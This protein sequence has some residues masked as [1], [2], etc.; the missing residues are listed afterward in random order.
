MADLT[1]RR[2]LEKMGWREGEGLGQRGDGIK[3]PVALRSVE[4]RTGLGKREADDD[5]LENA[6]KRSR[7]VLPSERTAREAPREFYCDVCD[8]QYATVSEFSN[9]LSSY[10]HHHRKRFQA[11]AQAQKNRGQKKQDRSHHFLQERIHRAK[12]QAA[13]NDEPPA[14]KSEE[15]PPSFLLPP[16]TPLTTTTTTT[17]K[18]EHA[19]VL[20]GDNPPATAPPLSS[21]SSSQPKSGQGTKFSSFSLLTKMKKLKKK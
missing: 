2:L 20:L 13:E 6:A 11:M 9:H 19:A 1:G 16:Q 21:S 18:E 14:T 3:A 5:A 8:K 7:A 4:G 12:A 10:D 17:R 15:A